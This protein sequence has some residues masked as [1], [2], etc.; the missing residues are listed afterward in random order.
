M[1]VACPEAEFVVLAII[2]AEIVDVLLRIGRPENCSTVDFSCRNQRRVKCR[3]I[4]WTQKQQ[5]SKAGSGDQHG[6]GS[7]LERI[8]VLSS[9]WMQLAFS[10]IN[11]SLPRS[12]NLTHH[13]VH[14]F[15]PRSTPLEL[16]IHGGYIH[17]THHQERP[18]LLF[19]FIVAR[20]VFLQLPSCLP[21]KIHPAQENIFTDRL[22]LGWD[23]S[24]QCDFILK[25]RFL[26]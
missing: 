6:A 25:K 20:P 14:V 1:V 2:G 24:H 4:A 10:L 3:N 16:R 7:N 26:T 22:L 21:S 17:T 18:L 5:Y 15:L 19:V 23:T 13:L 8:D 12:R 9:A 11:F